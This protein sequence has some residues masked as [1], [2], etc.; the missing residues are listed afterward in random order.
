MVYNQI[1]DFFRYY[2]LHGDDTLERSLHKAGF[3]FG[4]ITDVLLTHLHFDHCGGSIRYN[5]DKTSLEP[6]FPNAIYWSNQAHWKWAIEPNAREKASFLKENTLPIQESGQLKFITDGTEFGEHIAR[7]EERRVG[8]E[9]VSKFRTRW[10]PY[11]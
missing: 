4:D 5:S 8:K 6:A 7:S 9:C 2:Y 1:Y 3:D 10:S 11:H